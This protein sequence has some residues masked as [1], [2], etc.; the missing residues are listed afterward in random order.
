MM[1]DDSETGGPAVAPFYVP[2][3]YMT[4]TDLAP[5]PDA[6]PLENLNAWLLDPEEALT[7]RQEV[8]DLILLLQ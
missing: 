5:N 8:A 6:V 4:R 2:G 7:V 1:G 3:D